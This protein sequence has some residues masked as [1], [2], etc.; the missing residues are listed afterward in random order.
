MST[1][2]QMTDSGKQGGDTFV[3]DMPNMTKEELQD[4]VPALITSRPSANYVGNMIVTYLPITKDNNPIQNGPF[5]VFGSRQQTGIVKLT[6][7][8][9]V[10]DNINRMKI[11]PNYTFDAHVVCEINIG[12]APNKFV[13]VHLEPPLY[14]DII[15]AVKNSKGQVDAIYRA[16]LVHEANNHIGTATW[17]IHNNMYLERVELEIKHSLI[18]S[19]VNT[20]NTQLNISRGM[21]PIVDMANRDM[22]RFPPGSTHINDTNQMASNQVSEQLNT[23]D[24]PEHAKVPPPKN[25]DNNIKQQIPVN[26]PTLEQLKKMS[27]ERLSNIKPLAP[28]TRNPITPSSKLA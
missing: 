5:A 8:F 22:Q 13:L 14:D 1:N 15:D 3:M 19:W 20:V 28:P 18:A 21:I 7:E 10:T 6:A 25:D 16:P 4:K 24:F 26:P 9:T 2:K 17:Y 27:T 11:I 12:N 23:K